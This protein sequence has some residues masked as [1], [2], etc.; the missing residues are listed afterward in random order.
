MANLTPQEYVKN[1]YGDFNL[2]RAIRINSTNSVFKSSVQ[3]FI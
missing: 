3:F 2:I 1:D